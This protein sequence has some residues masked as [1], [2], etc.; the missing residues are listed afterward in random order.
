MAQQTPV[1]IVEY[2]EHGKHHGKH[3]RML[4]ELPNG[5]RLYTAAPQQEPVAYAVPCR[6][7]MRQGT[8]NGIDVEYVRYL[9]PY[10]FAAHEKG[11]PLYTAAPPPA[12]PVLSDE[13][14]EE[15]LKLAADVLTDRYYPVDKTTNIGL[16]QLKREKE[17]RALLAKV[18]P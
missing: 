11:I 5:T 16:L 14:F 9:K 3:I 8:L 18:R 10:A 13:E 15:F 17:L 12:A 2:I 7:E 6:N 4:T 1:A